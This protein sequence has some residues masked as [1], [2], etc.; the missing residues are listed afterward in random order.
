M[1]LVV[2]MQL[3]VQQVNTAL[4]STSQEVF[5]SLPKIIRD[6]K[7]LQDEGMVLQQKMGWVKEQITKIEM[8][9]GDS[10][11]VIENLDYIKTKLELAKQGLHESDNWTVLGKISCSIKEAYINF[12]SFILVNELEEMF[13]SRNIENISAKL[14]SMQYSLKLLVN[15]HDYEDRKLQL[16]GLKNR[17]EAI[18]SPLIVQAFT[19]NNIGL[20]TILLVTLLYLNR[21]IDFGISFNIISFSKFSFNFT[22]CGL[23]DRA[24]RIFCIK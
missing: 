7:A 12:I 2:K 20:Y 1:S 24:V 21:P 9:T 13:D 5:A 4:Q 18:V 3:Y 10:M 8:D 15:V 22:D 11:K 16:E 23:A 19:T 14:V 17:L 6:T